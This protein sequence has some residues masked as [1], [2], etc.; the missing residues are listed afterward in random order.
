MPLAVDEAAETI[1]AVARRLRRVLPALLPGGSNLGD[2]AP[3][4]LLES[5][6]YVVEPGAAAQR[7]HRDTPLRHTRTIKVQLSLSDCSAAQAPL[8]VL[9]GTHRASA[10]DHEGG[11]DEAGAGGPMALAVP[12]GSVVVY[13]PHLRH[14]GGAY[15]HANGERRVFAFQLMGEFGEPP[16]GIPYTIMLSDIGQWQLLPTSGHVQ[17][18]GAG[19]Q[20][21]LRPQL[22]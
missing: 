14:R 2:A 3:L 13:Q 11:H 21:G 20:S 5:S 10:A 1:G 6:A 8:E 4:Q 17:R 18:L 19:N 16:P 7:Y 15:T 22:S 12:E 9:P